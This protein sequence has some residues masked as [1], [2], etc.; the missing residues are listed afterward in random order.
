MMHGVDWLDQDLSGWIASEKMDGC[1]AYWT[2]AQL[3]TKSGRAYPCPPADLLRQLP[4]HALDCELWAPGRPRAESLRLASAAALRGEW[5]DALR[6]AAFDLPEHGG[7]AI[8]RRRALD[9]HPLACAW[10]R[11]A[12]TADALAMR[13]EVWR[14]G[15]EGVM[16][17]DPA[18]RYQAG[19]RPVLLKLK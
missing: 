2:G 18:G 3:L 19:R 11:V 14:R 7:P 8:D 1:R 17:L 13:A 12:S 9:I 10:R 16:L 5:S 15:G 6:L 4:A